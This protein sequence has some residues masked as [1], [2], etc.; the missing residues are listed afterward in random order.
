MTD[1]DIEAIEARADKATPGPW[2]WREGKHTEDTKTSDAG[3]LH[4]RTPLSGYTPEGKRFQN[5]NVAFPAAKVGGDPYWL[6]RFRSA[7][8]QG[9]PTLTLALEVF[10]RDNDKEFIA[11]ARED[12]PA[13]VQEV[14][15]LRGRVGCHRYG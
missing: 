4:T 5:D 8:K 7:T 9:K 11:Q 3:G 6:E 15:R 1:S 14:Q 10:A 13:L 12:I 2:Y